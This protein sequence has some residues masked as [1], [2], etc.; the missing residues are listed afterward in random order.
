M[1]DYNM[2]IISSIFSFVV[3]IF[4]LGGKYRKKWGR[5]GAVSQRHE[6]NIFFRKKQPMFKNNCTFAGFSKNYTNK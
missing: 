6:K 4:E 3:Y 1:V 2:L 5:G